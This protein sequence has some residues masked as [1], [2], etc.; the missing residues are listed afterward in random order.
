[1]NLIFFYF[2]MLQVVYEGWQKGWEDEH[3]GLPKADINWLKHDIQ[4]GLFERTEEYKQRGGAICKRRLL[5]NQ[6]WFYPPETPGVI[7]NTIPNVNSFFHCKVFFWRPVGVWR[8]SLRCPRKNCSSSKMK[9]KYLYRCGYS[10][11]VR[12]IADITGWYC[13]LTEI[14]G[15]SEC[16]KDNPLSSDR[17]IG[18]FHAWRSDIISQ[19][20]PGH[21]EMFPAILT[22][23]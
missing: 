9:G 19:L 15:C 21:Q 3:H 23:K 22:S 12:Y 17:Q 4:R 7:T 2:K 6:M 18:R 16:D 11:T 20:T 5:K 10:K 13:M 8:Y 14:L 1:M